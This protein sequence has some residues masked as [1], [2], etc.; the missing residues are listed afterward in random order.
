MDVR[1]GNGVLGDPGQ[2]GGIY[3][4]LDGVLGQRRLKQRFVGVQA[5]RRSHVVAE[6]TRKLPQLVANAVEGRLCDCPSWS[7]LHYHLNIDNNGGLQP[8]W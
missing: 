7:S 3:Q 4:L 8:V 1:H 6:V 5:G 2:R